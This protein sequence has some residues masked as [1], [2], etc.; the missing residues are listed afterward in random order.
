MTLLFP[1]YHNPLV[2]SW[3]SYAPFKEGTFLARIF[4]LIL[5]Y[6]FSNNNNNDNNRFNKEKFAFRR[7][8]GRSQEGWS[9]FSW[10]SHASE[11]RVSLLNMTLAY[12]N[13]NRIASP[14]TS[15]RHIFRKKDSLKRWRFH[16]RAP[17]MS[18]RHLS[19]ALF[20]EK[21]ALLWREENFTSESV[22]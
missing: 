19:A 14:M 15:M 10:V 6:F 2:E 13:R 16:L 21:S 22:G 17:H 18:E 12:L 5:V 7:K 8:G 20:D 3:S 11:T 4:S 1:W 9:S